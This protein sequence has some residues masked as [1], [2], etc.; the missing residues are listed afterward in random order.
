MEKQSI[1]ENI[2]PILIFHEQF[3]VA[4]GVKGMV[5]LVFTS[6]SFDRVLKLLKDQFAPQSK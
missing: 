3:T 4:P 2:S 6:P 1:T 5:M